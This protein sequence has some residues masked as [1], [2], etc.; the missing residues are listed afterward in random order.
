MEFEAATAL[1]ASN[2]APHTSCLALSRVTTPGGIEA[3]HRLSVAGRGVGGQGGSG[4]QG[5][6]EGSGSAVAQGGS[7]ASRGSGGQGGSGPAS[8]G[9]EMRGVK[10][11]KA[12][13]GKRGSKDSD[14][15]PLG[16]RTP[17]FDPRLDP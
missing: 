16:G 11:G 15:N 1:G 6:R 4:G 2:A 12:S 14:L 5:V 9:Q 7:E 3:V 10:G 17:P 13:G 8:R